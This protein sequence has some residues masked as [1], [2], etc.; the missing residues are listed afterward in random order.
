M[1]VLTRVLNAVP[2]HAVCVQGTNGTRRGLPIERSEATGR[3]SGYARLW[4]SF[5]R[6]QGPRH[7]L[8]PR[9]R[10]G[11]TQFPRPSL[12]IEHLA[13]SEWAREMR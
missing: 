6:R 13:S 3:P 10:P 12:I 11:L 5:A 4:T 7:E 9:G 8:G 2:S 1:S